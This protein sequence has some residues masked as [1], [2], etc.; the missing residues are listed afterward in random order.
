[1]VVDHTSCEEPNC[2][3]YIHLAYV[4]FVIVAVSLSIS[5]VFKY[6]SSVQILEYLL[7]HAFWPPILWLLWLI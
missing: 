1:V 6:N 4:V 5:R 3:G 7:T 2:N